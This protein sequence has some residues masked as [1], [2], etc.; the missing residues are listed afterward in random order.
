MHKVQMEY[1]QP[2]PPHDKP[3]MYSQLGNN[4]NKIIWLSGEMKGEQ[5]FALVTNDL[6]HTKHNFKCST[7]KYFKLQDK[8]RSST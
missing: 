1:M 8:E 5:S 4:L 6:C 7:K 3:F 2:I